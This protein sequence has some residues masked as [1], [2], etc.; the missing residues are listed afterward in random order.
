MGYESKLCIVD[1]TNLR[2]MVNGKS[3]WY[4]RVIATFDL[5]KVGRLSQE[6][7]E[8]PETN[9]YF[10]ADDGNTM[11]LSDRYGKPLKE[12]PLP[13]AIELLEEAFEYCFDKKRLTPCIELLKAFN[14]NQWNNLVVLHYGH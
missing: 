9:A 6:F 11:V 8:F 12:V 13:N 14:S 4:S 2:E 1:K 7:C 10:Y 5:G 3:M